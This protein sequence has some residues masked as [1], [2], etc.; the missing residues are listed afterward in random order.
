MVGWNFSSSP[1]DRV[2]EKRFVAGSAKRR[3]AAAQGELSEETLASVVPR[4]SALEQDQ[5]VLVCLTVAKQAT[6]T[7]TEILISE[8]TRSV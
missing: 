8:P 4:S 3:Y 6:V 1:F 2:V 7:S 5:I